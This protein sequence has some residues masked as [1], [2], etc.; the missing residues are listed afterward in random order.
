MILKINP[1]RRLF[2][3]FESVVRGN[4]LFNYFKYF[5]IETRNRLTSQIFE[6]II[7]LKRNGELWECSEKSILRIV[8]INKIERFRAYKRMEEDETV[9]KKMNEKKKIDLNCTYLK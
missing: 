9:E 4:K 2:A 6:A 1:L 3:Y 7:I 5:K 8:S